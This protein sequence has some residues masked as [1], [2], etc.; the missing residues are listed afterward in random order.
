M[1]RITER[2]PE[3]IRDPYPIYEELRETQP[4]AH[5]PTLDLHLVSRHE[6]VLSVLQ[7]SVAMADPRHGDAP[8]PYPE[9]PAELRELYD[10]MLSIMPFRDGDDHVRLRSLVARA[11]TPAMV[12]RLEPRIR[13]L[14]ADL[15]RRIRADP[16][17]DLIERFARPLPVIVMAELLGVPESERSRFGEWADSQIVFHNPLA[18]PD[19]RIEALRSIEAMRACFF[20]LFEDKRRAQSDDLIGRMLA[21]SPQVATPLELFGLCAM[22]VQAGHAPVANGIANCVILLSR[23]AETQAALRADP[24][25]M[26]DAVDE[27][28][29]LESPIQMAPRYLAA[30]LELG[31]VAIP[32]GATV[33]VI[34][35][36]ANRDPRAF[37]APD[38]VRLGRGGGGS[39]TFSRGHHFCL[40][41]NL[42]RREVAAA[43]AALLASFEK[44][45]VDPSTLEYRPEVFNRGP[46]RLYLRA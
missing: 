19:E 9:P 32:R 33:V 14:A 7:S 1:Y 28:L 20:D 8:L 37:D 10:A 31:G 46:Q 5:E 25:R 30:E 22:L 12:S 23:L 27:F 6:D 44:L 15:V 38:E 35:G 39:L 13:E 24:T 18:P 42:A 40:G 29:R 21:Q 36:S 11:F 16:Q 4:V 26:L 34:L 17:T 43:L 45:E 2:I 3:L 41:S